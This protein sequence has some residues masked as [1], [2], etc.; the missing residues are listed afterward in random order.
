MLRANWGGGS[1]VRSSEKKR[2]SRTNRQPMTRH[3]TYART[4]AIVAPAPPS[5][6][7]IRLSRRQ[8]A[9]SA[10]ERVVHSPPVGERCERTPAVRGHCCTPLLYRDC[11]RPVQAGSGLPWTEPF[12]ISSGSW[13]AGPVDLPLSSRVGEAW[14]SRRARGAPDAVQ[15]SAATALAA[16]GLTESWGFFWPRCK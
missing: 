3:P 7:G 1:A 16:M 6:P 15:H 4:T 12:R 5:L 10:Y 9:S 11:P 13:A 14:P 8:P 2:T